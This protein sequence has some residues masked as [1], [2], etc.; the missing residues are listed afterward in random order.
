MK[1]FQEL[2]T[3]VWHLRKGGFNQI[4]EWRARR[5]IE[6]GFSAPRDVNGSEAGW[7]GRASR[8]RLS[9]AAS[10]YASA[11]PRRPEIKVAVILD[12]FSSLS[13]GLEWTTLALSAKGWKD[14][15]T[16]FTPDLL[17]VES[18]WNGNDR[19]W[20]GKVGGA[21]G[22]SNELK[23]L[24]RWCGENEI[25]SVFWNKEDPPHYDEF[26]ESAFLFDHVFTSDTNRVESYIKDLGHENVAVLPFAAQPAIHNPVRPA[27]GWHQRDVAFAGMYFV[28]KYPE[29]RQQMEELLGGALD[30]SSKMKH[31]LEIFSRALDGDDRYQFPEPFAS[32]VVG[33]LNYRQMLTAYKAYKVFLNV[34]SVT[35]SPSMCARRIFEIAASGTVVISSPSIALGQFFTEDEVPVSR[36][37]EHAANL[38]LS[39][40]KNPEL[41]DRTV[42]LAQRNIWAHH[43]YAHRAETVLRA[44]SPKLALEETRAKVSALVSTIRPHQIDHVFSTIAAQEGV[45][46]Q[47]VLLLHGIEYDPARISD[48]ADR[49]GITDIV[50]LHAPRETPLGECLNLL[51]ASADAEI[52]TKMDDDDSYGPN[53]LADQVAALA[54][55]NA[56]IVGKHAHYVHLKNSQSNLLRFAH[57]EHRF[58]DFVMGPTIMAKKHV[59]TRVPFQKIP[60][61][62]DTAF[63]RDARIAGFSVY[64]ADRFNYVQ[65]RGGSEHTWQI[66]DS[67]LLAT[68]KL[69]FIGEPYDHVHF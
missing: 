34:N 63:L 14:E 15:L 23:A 29:R 65:V 22:P 2:R 61:G 55:S 45:D 56:D 6:L 28:H 60:R 47:L 20:R 3:A 4:R 25:P 35:D 17:F 39:F 53:Y 18:A 41:N 30:V 16:D 58:S 50:V 31:G 10:E 11:H 69:Q 44:A 42:H 5:R 49:F 62:E 40:V 64:S 43:T 37:R 21:A 57:K 52:L 46:V 59:F 48:L 32:R 38:A 19:H 9:F 12:D 1:A 67:E 54:Y 51:V 26:I 7:I 66:S 24:L 8:R 33:S 68:S 36:S 13:F 27:T